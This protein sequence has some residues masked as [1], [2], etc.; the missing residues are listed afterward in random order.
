MY[1]P[2]Q[3]S[4]LYAQIVEQIKAQILTSTHNSIS[5]CQ[6]WRKAAICGGSGP[7]AR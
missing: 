7:W 1:T 2:I 3:P 5:G 6:P 4:R